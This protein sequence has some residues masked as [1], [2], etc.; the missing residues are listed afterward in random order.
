MVCP[1]VIVA[2]RSN[3]LLDTKR[4]GTCSLALNDCAPWHS[5][6]AGLCLS[7][8]HPNYDTIAVASLLVSPCII[9]W[10]GAAQEETTITSFKL[11]MYMTF[12]AGTPK[13]AHLLCPA[14]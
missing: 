4:V 13:F 3:N 7:P 9:R 10:L 6:A 2:P 1:Q 14:D 8:S 11:N 5:A 12:A